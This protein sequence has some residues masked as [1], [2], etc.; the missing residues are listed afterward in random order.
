MWAPEGEALRE[1]SILFENLGCVGEVGSVAK[2]LES[3]E[4]LRYSSLIR[5]S[6]K[7]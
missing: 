1:V 4:A 2:S 3:Q 5:D 7:M 6:L